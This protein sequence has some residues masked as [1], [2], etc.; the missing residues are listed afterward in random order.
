MDNHINRKIVGDDFLSLTR[1][2]NKQVE[3]MMHTQTA[4]IQ[5]KKHKIKMSSEIDKVFLVT[6][7]IT[8]FAYPKNDISNTELTTENITNYM[9]VYYFGEIT[10]P[11]GTI[12]D[13]LFYPGSFDYIPSLKLDK[14]ESSIHK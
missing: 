3:S 13:C 6:Q 9:D 8:A 14:F 5:Q 11:A 1:D 7:Y 2:R 12:K 4:H 10:I